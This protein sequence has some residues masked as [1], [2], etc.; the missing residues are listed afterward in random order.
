MKRSL[1]AWMA[2]GTAAAATLA[3]C[4]G[5][6][7]EASGTGTLRLALTDAP[8]CGGYERVWVTVEKVRVHRSDIAGPND[9]GWSEVVLTA[10]QRID[11]LEYTNG[12]VLPLGQTQL[13]AGTYTQMRLVLSPNSGTNPLANAIKPIGSAETALDTPSGQQ[14]GLKA[15]VNLTVNPDTVA[16]F[17]IDFNACKSF[18]RAGNSGKYLLKPVLSVY[19]VISSKIVGWVDLAIAGSADVSAQFQG[20]APRFA[21]PDATT[22]RF[23][24]AWVPAG[25]Y[26][27]VITAPGRVNAVMTGVPVT[28][29]GATTIGSDTARLAPPAAA[30]SA[31]VGGAVTPPSADADVRA[32]QTLTGDTKVEVA[33]AGANATTGAYSMTLPRGALYTAPYVAGATTFTFTPDPATVDKYTLEAR[34]GLS[35]LMRDITL[36]VAGPV[37]FAFP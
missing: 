14:S 11:L 23:E 13:P 31:A 16:D 21:R 36:P 19:P 26:E 27:L 15:N 2:A 32:L 20:E 34:S 24:L 7:G 35:T 12:R 1:W 33:Y 18:V 28:A 22:G 30:A 10:P 17:V 8:A 25:N 37:D 9:S 3:A 29:A 4:G 6:G 5:G